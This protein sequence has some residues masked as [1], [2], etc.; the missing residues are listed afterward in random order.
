[1]NIAGVLK[2]AFLITMLVCFAAIGIGC[3]VSP[4]WGI[5]NFGSVYLRGG[6]DL[7]RE[8][9]RG[10]VRLVGGAMTAFVIYLVFHLVHD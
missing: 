7:R 3:M 2:I 5:R 6:G 9:N 1:V 10:G 8:W 4:D